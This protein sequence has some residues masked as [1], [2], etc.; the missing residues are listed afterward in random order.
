MQSSYE[1]IQGVDDA[2]NVTE[3][4]EQDVDEQVSSTAAL[5]ENS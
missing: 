2:G 5:K 1:N 3:D 4:G